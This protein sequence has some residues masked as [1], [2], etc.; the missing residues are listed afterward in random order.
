MCYAVSLQML[1]WIGRRR[2]CQSLE[3]QLAQLREM[4][5]QSLA[6]SPSE[7][8]AFPSSFLH[9]K[10]LTTRLFDRQENGHLSH[11]SRCVVCR[12]FVRDVSPLT[13]TLDSAVPIGASGGSRTMGR[14]NMSG[15]GISHVEI[16]Y[17]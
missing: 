8:V 14:G 6:E 1:G 5:K 17:I 9:S 15:R 10:F 4:A 12:I 2:K 16:L 3:T 13:F 11:Q 7:K